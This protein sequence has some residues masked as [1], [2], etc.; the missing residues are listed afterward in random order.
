MIKGIPAE[1][2]K[3]L[4]KKIT[5]IK[6]HLW[7]GNAY[8]ALK[9]IDSLL[10]EYDDEED[11]LTLKERKLWKT[12]QEFNTYID[13]N[14]A[15]V[16][17]Y[18]DRYKHGEHISTGFV[19]S[20]VNELISKIMA[21]QQQMRWTKKGAHLLLQLRVKTLNDELREVFCKWYPG[22]QPINDDVTLK[23]A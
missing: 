6:W 11:N 14:Q 7:H 20:T 22:L 23:V 13:Y 19:E 4:E 8:R 9:I 18:A 15:Y 17:C 10:F 21:K 2:A 3:I 5:S 12:I 1:K 16:V